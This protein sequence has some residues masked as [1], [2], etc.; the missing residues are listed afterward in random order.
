MRAAIYTRVSTEEQA[1]SGA[2]LAAQEDAARAHAGRMGAEVSGV[3][4]DEGGSGSVGLEKRPELLEAI[5]TL[6]KGD[7]LIVAKRDRIGRLDPMAMAMIQRAVERKGARIVSAAGGGTS[8]D[9]PSEGLVGGGM[10]AFR[11]DERLVVR[12]RPPAAGDGQEPRGRGGG[13]VP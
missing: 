8:P 4:A 11:G 9:D 13:A 12:G 7:V 6:R 5:A 10:A 1:Q 2:G 3:F